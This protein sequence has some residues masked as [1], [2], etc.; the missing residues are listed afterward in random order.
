M[1][2]HTAKVTEI[3]ENGDAIVE[4]PDELVKELN[5]QIGDTLDY[6]MK[7]EAVFIKNLSKEKRD[8]SAT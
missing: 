4:L 3:C 7:D 2:I 5:W 8:A 6:Q 1:K